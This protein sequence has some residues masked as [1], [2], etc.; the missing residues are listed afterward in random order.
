[1]REIV[2]LGGVA[3]LAGNSRDP[4]L[5]PSLYLAMSL[6][7]ARGKLTCLRTCCVPLCLEQH[8]DPLYTL[9]SQERTFRATY[10]LETKKTLGGVAACLCLD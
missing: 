2:S 9:A 7:I 4:G 6:A 8:L 5:N 1:M 3:A 10:L